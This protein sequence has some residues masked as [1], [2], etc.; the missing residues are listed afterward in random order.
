MQYCIEDD[1]DHVDDDAGWV[2][3]RERGRVPG[4]LNYSAVPFWPLAV[5]S[6]L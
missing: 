6:S 2:G 5:H 3:S 1:V 4:L